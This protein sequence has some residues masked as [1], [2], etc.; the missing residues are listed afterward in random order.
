MLLDPTEQQFYLPAALIERGDLD[1]GAIEIV[2]EKGDHAALTAPDLDPAQRD[3]Q[4]RIALAGELDFV[5]GEDL[6]AIAV[7]LAQRP[8]PA[9]TQPHLPLRPGDE[10]SPAIIDVLPPVKAAIGLVEH[11]GRAGLDGHLTADLYVVD[12]GGGDHRADRHVGHWIVNDVQLHAADA[13]VPFSP[14]AQR[15]QR[16]RT[17]VDQANHL[18]SLLTR[19]PIRQGRKHREGLR[20]NPDRP[21]R[22]GIRKR[23]ADKL[24]G[25]QMVMV[26]RIGV[27]AGHQRAQAVKPG[28]LCVD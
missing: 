25:A 5:V 14:L 13:A 8:M 6:E 7:T 10:E 3:R 27:E 21:P 26:L 2:G 22:I 19:P 1:C 11:V 23:R 24:A 9:C 28:Q 20:K 18:R 17:G 16:N 4:P 12:I 15:V